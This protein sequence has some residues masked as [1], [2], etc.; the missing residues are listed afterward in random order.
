VIK[1]HATPARVKRTGDMKYEVLLPKRVMAAEEAKAA[2]VPATSYRTC[3]MAS[4]H[5]S[6]HPLGSHALQGLAHSS[7]PQDIATTD[8]CRD[9][10]SN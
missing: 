3:T 5:V 8:I 6:C 9:D 1:Y 2:E 7:Q 10:S 4:G